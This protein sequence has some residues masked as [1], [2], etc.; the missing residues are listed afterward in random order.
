M[1]IGRKGKPLSDWYPDLFDENGNYDLETHYRRKR[2]KDRWRY[3]P[4][5]TRR[6]LWQRDQ[7]ACVTCG[8]TNDLTIDHIV[9]VS[10]GGTSELNNLQLLCKRCHGQKELAGRDHY[11]PSDRKPF[12]ERYRRE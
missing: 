6:D 3:V 10:Y 1:P 7:G 8:A 4:A 9:P 11:N 5:Q 2:E 12:D